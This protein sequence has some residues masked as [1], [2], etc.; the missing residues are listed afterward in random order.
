MKKQITFVVA[1]LVSFGLTY[2]WYSSKGENGAAAHSLA[3]L[4]KNGQNRVLQLR[5]NTKPDLMKA[6]QQFAKM[7]KE[8]LTHWLHQPDRELNEVSFA[9][10]YL[11]N[12]YLAADSFATGLH[13]L[14]VSA[15]QYLNAFSYMKLGQIYTSTEEE[16]RQKFQNQNIEF[17][18]DLVA[19]L[20]YFRLAQGLGEVTLHEQGDNYVLNFVNK[21]MDGSLQRWEEQK[22]ALQLDI[23]PEKER[24]NQELEQKLNAYKQMYVTQPS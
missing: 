11:G 10:H 13:Y 12:R 5:V 4:A 23:E 24:M 16:V 22:K 1:L 7:D 2:W 18:Q 3:Q 17:K 14:Q 20:L 19:A 15:E 6:C 8:Q 21:Y 9:L